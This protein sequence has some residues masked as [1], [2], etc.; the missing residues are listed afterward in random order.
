MDSRFYDPSDEQRQEFPTDE[1]NAAMDREVRTEVMNREK[2]QEALAWAQAY[3]LIRG[4][5]DEVVE[6][7]EGSQYTIEL[8]LQALRDAAC[9][10]CDLNPHDGTEDCEFC[11]RRD[12]LLTQLA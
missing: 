8:L 3:K 5:V 6:I 2:R 4:G 1:G 10:K 12:E 11:Q 7:I 9:R